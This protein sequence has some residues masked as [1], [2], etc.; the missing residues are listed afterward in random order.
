[1]RAAVAG[2]ADVAGSV[3]AGFAFPGFS[4]TKADQMDVP[5]LGSVIGPVRPRHE[6]QFG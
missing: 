6:T 2:A 3:E 5:S 1:M 4:F